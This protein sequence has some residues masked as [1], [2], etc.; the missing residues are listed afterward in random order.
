MITVQELINLLMQVEDKSKQIV[1][2]NIN[3]D[4]EYNE[5]DEVEDFDDCVIIWYK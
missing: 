2:D 3:S 5:I 4:K 1:L